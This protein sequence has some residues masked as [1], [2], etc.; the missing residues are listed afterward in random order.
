M[1]MVVMTLAVGI[2]RVT[3]LAAMAMVEVTV[4]GAVEVT[5]TT[6]AVQAAVEEM[7]QAVTRVEVAPVET[8]H[9]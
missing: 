4:A 3:D 9:E 6:G 5:L 8:V 2:I 7:V 1:G